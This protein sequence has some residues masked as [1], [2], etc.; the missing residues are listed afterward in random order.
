MSST[1]PFKLRW[2]KDMFVTYLII[3]CKEKYQPFAFLTYFSV[4][5]C[6]KQ[7]CHHILSVVVYVSQEGWD[8]VSIITVQFITNMC[9]VYK[10]I[11]SIIAWRS[12]TARLFCGITLAVRPFCCV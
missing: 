4:A 5:V 7:L 11:G 12:Y 2:S 8:F 3:I 1:D 6:L 9:G 10:T